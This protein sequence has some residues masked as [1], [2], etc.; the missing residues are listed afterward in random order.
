MAGFRGLGLGHA[1][2]EVWGFGAW[3]FEVQELGSLRF[4]YG[5]NK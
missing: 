2:Y 3:K 4:V 1:V 5:S